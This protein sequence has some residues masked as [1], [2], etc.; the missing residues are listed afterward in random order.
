M[1]RE[2]G[3]L[4][5]R[6]VRTGAAPWPTSYYPFCFFYKVELF[7]QGQYLESGGTEV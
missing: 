5:L 1:G 2:C 7:T 4:D 3:I 6:M